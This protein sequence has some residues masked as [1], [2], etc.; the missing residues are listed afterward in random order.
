VFRIAGGKAALETDIAVVSPAE[1]LEALLKGGEPPLC[2]RVG[3]MHGE[4]NP[5]PAHSIALGARREWPRRRPAKK[6]SEIAPSQAGHATTS[7]RA[8]HGTLSL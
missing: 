8:D 5:D 7:H 3:F 4:Q 6:R 1:F 2:R